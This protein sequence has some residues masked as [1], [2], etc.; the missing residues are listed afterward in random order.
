M[1]WIALLGGVSC[2]SSA[3]RQQFEEP[4]TYRDVCTVPGHAQAGLE[5][6][7]TIR[8]KDRNGRRSVL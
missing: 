3:A 4:G 7:F 5:G 8:R 2:E 6:P 1:K